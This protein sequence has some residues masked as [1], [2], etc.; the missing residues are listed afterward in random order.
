LRRIGKGYFEYH[1]SGAPF[2]A[3]IDAMYEK[4]DAW[5]AAN[6][7]ANKPVQPPTFFLFIYTSIENIHQ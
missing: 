5:F 1:E 2:L 4:I 6:D 7:P 3:E